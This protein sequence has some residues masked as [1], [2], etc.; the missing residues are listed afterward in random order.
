MP[1]YRVQVANNPAFGSPK[2]NV[3]TQ[4]T[5]LT[6]SKGQNLADGI[7]YW[8]VAFVDAN[9]RIG[10]YSPVQSFTKEYPLPP[11]LWPTQNSAVSE[12][13]TF[14]WAATSGAAYYKLQYADNSNYNGS[15]TVTTDLT[16]YTPTKLLN[17]KSYFW[18]VQMYDVDRNPGSLIE[19]RFVVAHLLY[20]PVITAP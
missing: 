1:T 8:R 14:A 20:L 10:P 19:G 7:W 3:T 15:T 5:S 2:I 13:P 6:P 4:A 17:T 12:A 18:R 11:L 16:Q 9:N